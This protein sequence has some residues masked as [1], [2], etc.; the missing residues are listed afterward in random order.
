MWC[1]LLLWEPILPRIVKQFWVWRFDWFYLKLLLTLRLQIRVYKYREQYLEV[2]NH[3]SKLR[4]LN[5]KTAKTEIKSNITPSYT[6]LRNSKL[7]LSLL[8]PLPT[9]VATN[10]P[11]LTHIRYRFFCCLLPRTPSRARP[12]QHIQ[13]CL[14][15]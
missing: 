2:F 6:R 5:C 12:H 3:L 11:T 8:P 1:K 13:N 9:T 15:L 10:T 14:A 4:W 7:P